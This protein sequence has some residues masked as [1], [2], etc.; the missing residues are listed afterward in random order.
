M[1]N[2]V[3]HALPTQRHTCSVPFTIFFV[4]DLTSEAV[5]C[6]VKLSGLKRGFVTIVKELSSI[7][8]SADVLH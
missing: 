5:A 3:K 4:V 1:P 8:G 6:T 7:K 2:I